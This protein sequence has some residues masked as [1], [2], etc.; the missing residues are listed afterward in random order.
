MNEETN[1]A[2]PEAAA[3][4][5]PTKRPKK[6]SKSNR[7]T[8]SFVV[9]FIVYVAAMLT[10][11]QYAINSE[12]NMWYLYQVARDT[13]WILDKVG[14]EAVVEPNQLAGSRRAEL[15]TW[16]NG[17]DAPP[18]GAVTD[19]TSPLTAYETWLYKAYSIVNGGGSL[20]EKGP[21]VRFTLTLGLRME[22][23][24]L[25]DRRAEVQRDQTLEADEKKKQRAALD[26]ELARL[27]E[28]DENLPSGDEGRARRNGKAFSFTL[29]PDCGA[30]PSMSIFIAAVIA[31]PARWW[32]R[33]AGVLAGVP[34]LYAVNL[35]RISSLGYLG[36]VEGKDLKWFDFAHHY[37]WQ[38][39]FIIFVVALW[40]A[41]I[42]FVVRRE[43]S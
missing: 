33:I 9:L 34:L 24:L 35:G 41:W 42:E 21:L 40:M 18:E 10:G 43:R 3:E 27:E 36:A 29:V 38:G 16:R 8:L 22:Q 17:G 15:E 6:P 5:A 28:E 2:A 19:D 1:T 31:F 26:E 11:Y 13:G 12:A 25:R 20:Q 4:P 39:I 37:V 30:I 7:R 32:K 14:E 23:Q